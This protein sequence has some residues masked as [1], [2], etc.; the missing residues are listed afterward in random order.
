MPALTVLKFR[1][2]APNL[3]EEEGTI[4][5]TYDC[6][7]IFPP[8]VTGL[9]TKNAFEELVKKCGGQILNRIE[10]GKR[11]LGYPVKKLKEGYLAAF[12]VQLDPAQMGELRRSLD[13]SEEILKYTIVIKEKSK[14]A[15]K[16]STPV[17]KR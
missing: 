15:K 10:M 5:K 3:K 8:T 12:D 4:L 1:I 7:V 14:A 16:L 6:L 2:K 13:L 9:D 17:E 11:F